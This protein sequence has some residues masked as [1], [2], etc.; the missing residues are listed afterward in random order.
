MT[1]DTGVS[2]TFD[3]GRLTFIGPVV[4]AS[5]SSVV[6]AGYYNG[7]LTG[8]PNSLIAAIVGS[9]ASISLYV[10]DGGTFRDAGAGSVSS[11]GAFNVATASGNRVT[12][13]IDP[14][15]GFMTASLTGGPGGPVVAALASGTSIS[16]GVL[17]NLSTRGQVGSGANVLIA[18]FVVAGSSTKQ[19]LIRAIG[20]GLTVFGVNGALADPQLQ[21]FRGSLP[22]ASNDQWSGDPATL[23]AMAQA[24]AF[25]LAPGSLDSALLLTLAPG[26]YTAHVSGVGGRTGVALIE[27]YDL[28]DASPFSAQKVTNVATRG[29]VGTGQAQLIA[30]FAISGNMPKKV[31]IR[32]VGPSLVNVGIGSG[33]LAD[34][35]LRLVRSDNT[36]VRENDNWYAGNDSA[37]IADAARRVNAFAFA[38]GSRDAAILVSLPPGTY[39]AE[40]TGAGNTTGIALVEVYEVP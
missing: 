31:L 6:P 29:I 8:R 38:E 21:L 1:N 9:D 14:A 10:T 40:V 15:T 28:D 36:V 33:F 12:G 19:V 3:A 24:G 30:G 32:G 37:L 18:G 13:T 4:M 26:A 11:N 20:P 27:L 5:G 23:S 35:I 2:G 7:S 25:P 22:V 39:T 34:P 17:R 16:D